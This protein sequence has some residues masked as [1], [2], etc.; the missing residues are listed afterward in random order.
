[1][2]Q[3][4]KPTV[5]RIVHYVARGSADGAYPATC[6]AAIIT[7]PGEAPYGASLAVLNPEGMFF[8][9][10]VE[11]SHPADTEGNVSPGYSV[12]QCPETGLYCAGGTWHYLTSSPP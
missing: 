5:G 7:G 9:P 2:S 8:N 6:R 11:H 3:N 4:Q 12:G 1:M 10:D